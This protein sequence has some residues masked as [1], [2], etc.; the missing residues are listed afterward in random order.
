MKSKRIILAISILALAALACQTL[1][2]TAEPVV[3]PTQPSQF[4]NNN[5]PQ[6]EDDVP[7]IGVKEAKAAVDSGQAILV[8]V[9]GADIYAEQHAAGAMS[10]PLDIFEYDFASISL[11]KEQWI[12]TYCT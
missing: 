11:E 1:L 10:I 7:R 6:T 3:A 8:D 12:I 2:P 9:R 4:Q 5:A